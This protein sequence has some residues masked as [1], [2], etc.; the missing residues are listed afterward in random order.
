[1]LFKTFCWL[2][3]CPVFITSLPKKVVELSASFLLLYPP[4]FEYTTMVA[5]RTLHV[6]VFTCSSPH[7]PWAGTRSYSHSTV[8]TKWQANQVFDPIYY[9]NT[10]W[11]VF[12]VSEYSSALTLGYL[13]QAYLHCVTRRHNVWKYSLMIIITLWIKLDYLN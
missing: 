2:M 3:N 11:K 4:H 6:N 10:K 5:S 13:S 7:N 8:P 1:M 9:S 12:G